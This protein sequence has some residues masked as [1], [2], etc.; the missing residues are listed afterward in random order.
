MNINRKAMNKA[1][2]I[3]LSIV[4]FVLLIGCNKIPEASRSRI[5]NK[6]DYVTIDGLWKCTPETALKLEDLTIEPVVYIS[7]GMSKQPSAKGCFTWDGSFRDY[8]WLEK[9]EYN[10][11][12]NEI[13]IKDEDGSIY[14][15]K[16]DNKKQRIVG[17]VYSQDGDKLIPEDKLDLIR[18][19][20]F[21]VERLFIPRKPTE[22]GSIQYNYQI[23]AN[24]DDGL[25]TSSFFNYSK[26]T[27][28]LY[29]LI[30]EIIKQEYGRL[31]SFLIMKDQNLIFEEY[32]YNHSS[33][34][35]HNI[36]SCT[37]SIVS[38]AAGIAFEKVKK[39]NIEESIFNVFPQFDSLKNNENQDITL[40]H[41]LT[42]SAGFECDNNYKL[43]KPNEVAGS[44]L[45][46]PLISKPGGQFRYNSECPYFLG[47]LIYE[48]SGKT[49]A[50]FTKENIFSPLGIKEYIWKNRNGNPD[51][52]S[53]LYMQPRDMIKIGLLALN[54]GKWKGKQ[55]VPEQWINESTKPHIAE[56][57]FFNYG[58]QW[59]HRSKLNKPWW[60]EDTKDSKEYDM[61]LALGYGGQYIFIIKDL[62]LIISMTS[63]DYNEGNGM[64]F[65]KIPLVIEKIIPLFE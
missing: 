14:I 5:Q 36:F 60:K 11:S 22:D 28:A 10:D 17:M 20:D 13:K 31:E 33:T 43:V 55:I 40:K 38:L 34:D 41:I 61:F 23:P 42:M 16:I 8:W 57:D 9:I 52:E 64:A 29:D 18:A 12:T 39:L 63:S 15:G 53:N 3:I 4:I 30:N 24:S 59:W 35:L 46:L 21:N 25:Q 48:I 44:I 54:N 51:C 19:T 6:V 56:S 37:K 26:D 45:K 2:S 1:N 65:K 58:Y 7:G 62:N 50:E 49:I 47:G 32:F 27:S